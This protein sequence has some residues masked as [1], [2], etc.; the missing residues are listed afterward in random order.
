MTH[1]RPLTD[2]ETDPRKMGPDALRRWIDARVAEANEYRAVRDI[3]PMTPSEEAT[4]RNRY[5]YAAAR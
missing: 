3:P 4:L 1:P 2:A 5:R